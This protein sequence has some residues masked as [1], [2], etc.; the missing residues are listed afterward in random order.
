MDPGAY[1]LREIGPRCRTARDVDDEYLVIGIHVSTRRVADL[2]RGECAFDEPHGFE[3]IGPRVAL[4]V[5]DE[6]GVVLSRSD[7]VVRYEVCIHDRI[8]S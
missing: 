5:S 7:E 6:V 8:F 2:F 1:V 3:R 4:D